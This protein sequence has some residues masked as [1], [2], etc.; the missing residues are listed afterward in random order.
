V[1]LSLQVFNN[2]SEQGQAPCRFFIE[3]GEADSTKPAAKSDQTHKF[4][5]T[6]RTPDK[7]SQTKVPNFIQKFSQL[8]PIV[9]TIYGH[10]VSDEFSK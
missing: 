4:L 9:C 1:A 8:N 6:T 2:L 10:P 5:R 7:Q 3:L